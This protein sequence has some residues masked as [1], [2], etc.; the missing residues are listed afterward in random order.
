VNYGS[1]AGSSTHFRYFGR[2]KELKSQ[3]D[4]AAAA[5]RE[6]EKRKTFEVSQLKETDKVLLVHE[7]VSKR[8]QMT[9]SSKKTRFDDESELD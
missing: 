6:A 3:E 7:H 9:S 2:A 1:R 5:K 4:N 8:L